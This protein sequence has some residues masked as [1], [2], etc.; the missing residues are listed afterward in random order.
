M[1]ARSQV[2]LRLQELGLGL[3]RACIRR[4]AGVTGVPGR[5]VTS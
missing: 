2:E 3:T 4:H 5:P 1:G